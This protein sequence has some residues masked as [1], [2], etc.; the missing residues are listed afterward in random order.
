MTRS[1]NTGCAI[2][3]ALAIFLFGLTIIPVPAHAQSANELLIKK[4]KGIGDSLVR[5]Q[6]EQFTWV[7]LFDSGKVGSGSDITDRFDKIVAEWRNRGC[8]KSG[9][10]NSL[11]L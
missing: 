2:A 7:K 10:V 9:L 6:N 11:P 1:A 8:N 3:F 5:I 4:C